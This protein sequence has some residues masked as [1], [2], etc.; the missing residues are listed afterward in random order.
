[1]EIMPTVRFSV[2]EEPLLTDV[3]FEGAAKFICKHDDFWGPG[4]DY[5]SET[6]VNPTWGKVME[7]AVNMIQVVG[8]YNHIFLE[9]IYPKGLR[10]DVTLL[11]FFM[12]S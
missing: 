10:G 11:E 4:K 12:G 8:D 6:V 3:A 2:P 5:E 1:M 9:G 7:L